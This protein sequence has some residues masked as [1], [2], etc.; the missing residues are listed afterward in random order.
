MIKKYTLQQMQEFTKHM[1][2]NTHLGIEVV[3]VHN[4]GL[5]ISLN[6]REEFRNVAQVLHGGVTASMADAAVGLALVRHFAATMML[7]TIELKV[8]YFRP[9]WGKKVTARAKLIRVG[10][11]ICVGSVDIHDDENKHAGVALVTYMVLGPRKHG[12]PTA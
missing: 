2:F 4:D 5:T 11:Q 7:S 9:V 6:L 3:K 1:P 10:K 8:N 12:M